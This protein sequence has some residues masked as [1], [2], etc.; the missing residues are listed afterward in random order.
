MLSQ[1][2]IAGERFTVN[3]SASVYVSV[4]L[5]AISKI[6]QP[7]ILGVPGVHRISKTAD[8]TMTVSGAPYGCKI[9]HCVLLS[10]LTTI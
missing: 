3:A 8:L 5:G 1:R 4:Y 2:H 10:V 7:F 9:S 6:V